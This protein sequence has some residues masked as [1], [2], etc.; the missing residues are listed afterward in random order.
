VA[1]LGVWGLGLPLGAAV[2]LGAVL[3]P[4]DPVLASEVAVENARDRDR[5]RFALTGE[6]GLNDGAAFPL[7]LLG[8]G[9]LGHHAL[10]PGGARWLALDV[11]WATA[12]GLAIGAACGS[13]VARLVLHL[14]REHREAVGTDDFLALGLI[15]LSY[16]LAVHAGAYGFLSVFAAGLALRRVERKATGPEA[17]PD[18]R[19]V[20]AEE[21][22][23]TDPQQAPQYL[24]RAVLGVTEQL[25]RIGVVALVVVVGAALSVQ[26]P[27][28]AALWF[29]PALF[30]VVRPAAVAVGLWGAPV[31]GL[32]RA[33][34]GWFGLR[35]IGSLYYLAFA[36]GHGLGGP[37]AGGAAALLV[38]LTLW[39]VAA[40]VVVHGVS[41]T[42]LMAWY[43]RRA[44]GA[45]G[46]DRD[47]PPSAPTARPGPAG[48][49]L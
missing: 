38:P 35:G 19:A 1:A 24:A 42:P 6:A 31:T 18:V 36:L 2:L 39:T 23:A 28:R 17:P 40:S 45:R 37:G 41:V 47:G 33:L 29:V 16:G 49:P 8:L 15:A 27:P 14:R 32:Q 4:T 9:L 7:V 30:L 20:A 10:G 25:E 44:G 3:A 43:A 48:D 21:E 13:A 11:A 5:L 26:P 22:V 34:A 46:G 12:A